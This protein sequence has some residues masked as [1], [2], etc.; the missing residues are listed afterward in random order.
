MYC[1]HDW[2]GTVTVAASLVPMW[3]TATVPVSKLPDQFLLQMS[4]GIN[5][6]CKE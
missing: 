4:N 5:R 1:T 6:L 3:R 2:P